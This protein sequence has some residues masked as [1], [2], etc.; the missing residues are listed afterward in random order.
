[1]KV[2]TIYDAYKKGLNFREYLIEKW[3]SIDPVY[4]EWGFFSWVTM[5]IWCGSIWVSYDLSQTWILRPFW[6]DSPEIKHH[7][8][9]G[10]SEVVKKLP[11]YI[12]IYIYVYVYV[13]IYIYI[14]IVNELYIYMVKGSYYL[15]NG[16]QV[17]DNA[18]WW[19]HAWWC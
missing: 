11:K 1:L 12:Y 8:W 18:T 5:E 7:L 9:W 15:Y 16:K 2:P 13:Y 19:S 4:G 6:D 10:R 3:I 17:W 14:F